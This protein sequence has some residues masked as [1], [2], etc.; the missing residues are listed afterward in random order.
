M[1]EGGKQDESAKEEE[2]KESP[3]E[4]GGDY[5]GW[6]GLKFLARTVGRLCFTDPGEAMSACNGW[7]NLQ[8][9]L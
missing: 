7:S 2:I 5:C 4:S 8:L 6:F 1:A 9:E 3:A